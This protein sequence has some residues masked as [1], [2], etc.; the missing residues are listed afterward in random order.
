LYAEVQLA[1]TNTREKK[2]IYDFMAD[3]LEVNITFA[4]S[5]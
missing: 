2:G 1:K 4:I 3:D 5:Q